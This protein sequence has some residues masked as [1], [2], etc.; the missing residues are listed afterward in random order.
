M[1]ERFEYPTDNQLVEIAL[2]FNEGK[3]QKKKLSDMIAMS[4]FII[5]RLFE[6]GTITKRSS[7]EEQ[8]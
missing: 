1:N 2:L 7:K 3:I 4:I 6:N 8:K 5:D